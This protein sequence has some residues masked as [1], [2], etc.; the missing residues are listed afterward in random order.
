MDSCENWKFGRCNPIVDDPCSYCGE[1]YVTLEEI[2]LEEKRCRE[3]GVVSQGWL[4]DM[5]QFL[6]REVML[7]NLMTQNGNELL[8]MHISRCLE[9]IQFELLVAKLKANVRKQI[10]VLRAPC[11]EAEND[12]L[13]VAPQE[14]EVVV[15][16]E[17]IMG[18]CNQAKPIKIQDVIIEDM[19]L[20][21]QENAKNIIYGNFSTFGDESVHL[22]AKNDEIQCKGLVTRSRLPNGPHQKK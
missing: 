12:K 17:E 21:L 22:K 8:N 10:G 2:S 15:D 19:L 9:M 6:E 7:R 13:E 3:M 14:E 1:R 18:I 20:K 5:S 4:I 16:I 11:Q